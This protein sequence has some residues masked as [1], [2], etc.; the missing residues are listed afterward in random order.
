M[1]GHITD[2]SLREISLVVG[3]DWQA[4]RHEPRDPDEAL[5]TPSLDEMAA[6][7]GATQAQYRVTY[8]KVGRHGGRSGQP[9]PAPLTVWAIGSDGLA[10]HIAKDVRPYLASGGVEVHVDLELMQG[11]IFTGYRS[12]GT[13]AI[14][15]LAVAEGRDAQ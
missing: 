14:E 7:P 15:Q 13:F 3:P 1:N 10:G 5:V 12:G 9:A 4:G 11:T 6:A 2:D 8:D